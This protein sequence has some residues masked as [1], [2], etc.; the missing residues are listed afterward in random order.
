[1]EVLAVYN[2]GTSAKITSYT[3][4][5]SGAFTL[6]SDVPEELV[7]VTITYVNCI[8]T[9]TIRVKEREI[10]SVEVAQNPTRLEYAPGEKF[11]MARCV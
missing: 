9:Q 4:F 11:D 6:S 8:A 1:M 3:C 2:D 10:K 7:N 5:P